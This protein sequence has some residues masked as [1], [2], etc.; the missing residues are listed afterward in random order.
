MQGLGGMS[1]LKAASPAR[2]AFPFSAYRAGTGYLQ[3]YLNNSSLS[4]H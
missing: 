2:L 3:S 1:G 4:Y